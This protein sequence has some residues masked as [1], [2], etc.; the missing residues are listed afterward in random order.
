[1]EFS[2][3]YNCP[4]ENINGR[5][6]KVILYEDRLEL[7]IMK[8]N[9]TTYKSI[10]IQN[11]EFRYNH[12]EQ[13]K[14]PDKHFIEMHLLNYSKVEIIT[15]PSEKR[16]IEIINQYNELKKYGHGKLVDISKESLTNGIKSKSD[17]AED[18]KNKINDAYIH[19]K[20][21]GTLANILTNF[22]KNSEIHLFL[23]SEIYKTLEF[24]IMG[25]NTIGKKVLWSN[26][27]DINYIKNIINDNSLNPEVE[28][29]INEFIENRFNLLVRFIQ[30][31]INFENK[32]DY[33][34]LALRMLQL[35]SI[36]YFGS[37]FEMAYLSEININLDELSLEDCIEIYYSIDKIQN[38]EDDPY[39][40][41][42]TNYL[43]YKNKFGCR[44]SIDEVNFLRWREK[45]I[46][47]LRDIKADV[48]YR[49]FEKE[50]VAAKT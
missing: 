2:G 16:A 9:K 25:S 36:P 29:V 12:K 50:I 7:N 3:L 28:N 45:L 19:I 46:E 40:S 24:Y 41:L 34:F 22:L 33:N 15:V 5:V 4:N 18:Y 14:L 32:Y 21:D 39:V 31:L 6:C 23:N 42:F 49:I 11:I 8:E 17:I 13:N 48:K 35:S 10:F 20:E 37:M 47:M 43:L 27:D 26:Q 44:D 38:K 1:M 30:G